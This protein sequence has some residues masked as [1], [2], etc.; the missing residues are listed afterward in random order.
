[1]TR[2]PSKD[3]S[4]PAGAAL[5]IPALN[6]Y[7]LHERNIISWYFD[8]YL[9]NIMHIYLPLFDFTLDKTEDRGEG[10]LN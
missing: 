8:K 10:D 3:V 2:K 4:I 7:I 9:T 5:D 6:Y 1:M